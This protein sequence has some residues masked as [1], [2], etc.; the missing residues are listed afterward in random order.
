MLRNETYVSS[1]ADASFLSMTNYFRIYWVVKAYKIQKTHFKFYQ[2]SPPYF[3]GGV[4][5]GFIA[6]FE[7]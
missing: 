4:G 1:V 7:I 6:R 2:N 3:Q 5:G